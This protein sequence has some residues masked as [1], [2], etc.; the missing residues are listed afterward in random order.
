MCT[1]TLCI[2]KSK[3][4][5]NLTRC[6]KFEFEKGSRDHSKSKETSSQLKPVINSHVAIMHQPI[7]VSSTM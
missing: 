5:D 3:Q 7:T 4:V 1:Y 6:T 2:I